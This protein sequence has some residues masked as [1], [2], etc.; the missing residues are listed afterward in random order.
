[1]DI[2]AIGMNI[3]RLKL[4]LNKDFASG[5]D[6]LKDSIGLC[7]D[8]YKYKFYKDTLNVLTKCTF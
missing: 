3:N 6:G 8:N 4:A 7:L 1:M 5:K 2:W